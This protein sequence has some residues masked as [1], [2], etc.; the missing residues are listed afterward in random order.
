MSEHSAPEGAGPAP[1]FAKHSDYQVQLLSVPGDVTI[2]LDGEAI[3]TSSAALR[4]EESRHAPVLYVP[5]VDVVAEELLPSATETYCPFKG[6]ARY[7]GIRTARH[8]HPDVLWEYA[9][10][11]DEV[12]GL[13]GYVGVYADRVDEIRLP[14]SSA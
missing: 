9:D 11:F 2:W 4:V 12:V 7:Y 8:N 13:R 10:P 14:Q 6:T 5:L 1:G 3:C